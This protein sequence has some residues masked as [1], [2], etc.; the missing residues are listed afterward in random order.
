MMKNLSYCLML[1]ALLCSTTFALNAQSRKSLSPTSYKKEV[2][3]NVEGKSRTY[4]FLDT[5]RKSVITVKG[6]GKLQVLS[7]AQFVPSQKV[8]VNY[9]ILYTIDGG[10]QKQ[11]K[12]KSA[13]RSTKSTFVNGA[14]G[15]PGQLM[16]IEILLNR[17][18]HTIEFSL[19]ENSPG[20]ATRFIFTPTKEKKRE[21]IG[22]YTAQSSD[23][24]E[25]V[26]NETSVSYY[27]FSTE[28]PLRVEV[29]G[30]TELRVFTRVEFT[31]NM[32]GNVHYRVQVKNNDRIINTY[33]MSS[34]RS[35]ATSYLHGKD[36]VPGKACEFIID[37]PSGR[38]IYE[39][40]PLDKDKNSILVRMMIPKVDVKKKR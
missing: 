36:L 35:E 33:Q 6:P 8:K 17:G 16:K 31:Y 3:I 25:L 23:I 37:V 20:V 12:V 29:I 15:V 4:Y 9:N 10:T 30:P 40:I 22:F 26:A 18:T 28:K 2:G 11:I 32:R 14:L 21:W 1:I 7:R 39:L 34:R 5:D 19:P 13:V 38:Q 24:V 27:R